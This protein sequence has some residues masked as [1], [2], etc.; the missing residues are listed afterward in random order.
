MNAPLSEHKILLGVTG[1][2]AAY[3]ACSLCR[4]LLTNGARVKVVM[5]RAG[6]ALV[7]PNTFEAL[8]GSP[9]SIDIFNAPDKI[10]HIALTRGAS[11]FVIAPATANTIAKLACGIADNMVTAGVLAAACPV[12]VVP[13]MN[14]NM[15]HNPATLDNLRT[16]RERGIYIMQPDRGPL[17]CGISGDGRMP[18]P[19]AILS[20]IISLLSRRRLGFDNSKSLPA[21]EAPAELPR[22]RLLPKA[23]GAGKKVVITAGPTVEALDPVRFISNR[24][25]G[26]MGY[27]L[28]QAFLESGASVTLIS[29]PVNL[30]M[31]MGVRRLSVKSAVEM[32]A[33]VESCLGETDIFIGCAAV[34]DYRAESVSPQKLTKKEHPDSLTLKLVKN[35]DIIATV[36]GRTVQRPFTAGFA[37]ETE[38]GEEHARAKL[39]EKH[40]DLIILNNVADPAIGFDSDFN[41]VKVF[42]K[43]G[44]VAAFEQ[45]PKLVLARGLAELILTKYAEAPKA[46]GTAGA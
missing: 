12:V 2:I 26:K 36:A 38:R 3:K 43:D 8:S 34:A 35:P 9:V 14:T 37:A 39:A 10:S 25:S 19:E 23:A 4:L 15:F 32:L 33:A 24:S 17:A 31:P 42:D 16:L 6:A 30:E 20:Y 27:A 18:E 41:A 29:G 11:L 28:A 44:A 1:S 46:A 22:T 21:P 5:T 45:Q 13:A 7:N 40:L